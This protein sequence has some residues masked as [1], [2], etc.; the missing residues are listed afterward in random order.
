MSIVA[1]V[2]FR[3]DNVAVRRGARGSMILLALALVFLALNSAGAADVPSVPAG[4]KRLLPT[5]PVWLDA[6]NKR[7]V[8]V[9]EVVQTEGQMEM[10]A[11]LKK[12]KEH[13]SIL[14]I[15]T[16]AYAVHAGLVAIG[17]EPGSPARFL[18]EYAPAR[19]TEINIT[20]YWTAADGQRKSAPAQSWLT[21]T[22]TRLPMQQ[23]WVFGGSGFWVD[24]LT[25]E[26][27]YQAEEGDFICVSNFTTALLD[28]PVQS[29]QANDALLFE[30][31]PDVVPPK[32]TR[33]TVVLTPQ[34]KD[35][36][37]VRGDDPRVDQL[38]ASSVSP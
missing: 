25:K 37:A 4:F 16:Q 6:T 26:R 23:S 1:G 27:H 13:E 22:R 24:P 7:L 20:L 18:P 34:L 5:A 32:G 38:P 2:G 9:G 36:P 35:Q 12:T 3:G 10:F 17:A 28:V 21:N 11:C 19:G 30:A 31:N 8:M 15:D 29:S 33:V 14:A